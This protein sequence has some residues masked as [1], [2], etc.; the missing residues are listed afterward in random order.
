MEMPDELFDYIPDIPEDNLL[1]I[2][3]FLLIPA[4]RDGEHAI[5]NNN[6]TH[7]KYSNEVQGKLSKKVDNCTKTDEKLHGYFP[8]HNSA[9]A[10]RGRPPSKPPTKEVL[11][12][13]R[14]VC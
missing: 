7:N 14:K 8:S 3:Q 9:K 10:K 5:D 4:S 11:R 12:K 2:C 1:E 6:N 13:R